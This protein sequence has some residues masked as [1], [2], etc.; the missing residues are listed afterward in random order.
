MGKPTMPAAAGGAPNPGTYLNGWHVAQA[1]CM[2]HFFIIGEN[3][4]IYSVKT[5]Q[6]KN[7]CRA[8]IRQINKGNRVQGHFKKCIYL[9]CLVI[10]LWYLKANTF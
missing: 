6:H 3:I 2:H 1:L 10:I 4:I 5:T 9:V 8:E 7:H